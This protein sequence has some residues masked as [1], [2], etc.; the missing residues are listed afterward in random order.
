[1]SL[2]WTGA[3]NPLARQRTI[4]L[5]SVLPKMLEVDYYLGRET[6]PGEGG[7]T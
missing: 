2:L 1:M 6:P 4:S 7:M 5:T 3:D